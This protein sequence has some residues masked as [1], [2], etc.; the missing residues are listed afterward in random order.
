MAVDFWSPSYRAS[1]SDLTVAISPL[2]L[3]ELADEEFEVHGP[4]LNRYSAA[5]AWYLG[6]HWAY[7]REFGESQFY[8]N[9]VR[10]MSDYITNFTFGKGVQF[11]TPEQN[12]A[13]IP[14]LLNKVWGQHNNKEH[15]LWEMGQLASVT[16]DCFVKV[17]YEEPYVDPIGIPIPGKIRILPLNPAHCFPEYHP[18][19]R[20]RL[21]RFKLKYRF[22]GTASEGTRQ[23]YTFTEIITDDT[24]EQY[25]ND[26]LVDT[27]PNAIG[28]IPIV[29]IP[30]TTISSSPWGQSDIWDIIPLNRELNEKM[31]EVS[32]IINYHAAP[33]TIITG[34]KASQ[35]ERGP[36]KVWAGLPKDSNV[37]NLESR[38]E[39][40]G[41]LEY[42]SVIKRTM[43]ELT[44]VPETAL[45]QTQPISNTSGVALA[46]QYQPM[47]N[48]Y[49]MKKSHFTRGLERVNEI[50]IRT[51]AIFQP[52]LL[53]YDPSVSGQPEKDNA[54][55][56]DPTDPLTYQTTCHWPDPLPVDVLITLNEV[57]AKL[58]LGLESK[59]GALK[60]L[61]EEFPN[62]K[63]SEV[64]EEQMDDALDQG[65]LEMF[66]AQ[67]QQAIFAATGML[68]P[69]GATP[70]GNDSSESGSE[71]GGILPGVPAPGV[72]AGMLDNLIQ[73]AYGARFAQRRV[74]EE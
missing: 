55:E 71:G 26:E 60:L 4:R 20:T 12:N 74:P 13:I 44:G 32:D 30:N 21:L 5:W 45:G 24:V 48:R 61:G 27:Y 18:H 62:E 58:A 53:L 33:V 40:S 9:Y 35:L 57:Q 1:A 14:H 29:H 2:G 43:H 17:A 15:V 59:R 67:V 52:H 50:V 31:A 42:I 49:S 16:G 22:W 28:H 37:F 54:I 47:M 19:D 51:A 63:M 34:A 68:P 65:S 72:D 64:F 10:T 3:V 70:A 66:N 25:I 73:R 23:V 69:E 6:H 36:K 41:A 56:L 8:M 46:I 38:G 39:M 11:R 7:R